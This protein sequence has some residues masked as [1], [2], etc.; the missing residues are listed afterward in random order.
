[1]IAR[2]HAAPLLVVQR[3]HQVI[4]RADAPEWPD[5]RDALRP[6]ADIIASLTTAS[7]R[8]G[9]GGG[10]PTLVRAVEIR[11]DVPELHRKGQ[12]SLGPAHLAELKR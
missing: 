1:M 9:G 10:A 3:N 11:V 6:F 5:V 4:V 8:F 12:L 7:V 2:R